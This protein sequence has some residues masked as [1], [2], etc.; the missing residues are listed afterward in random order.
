MIS[1]PM[2]AC[3]CTDSEFS[4]SYAASLEVRQ[5][6]VGKTVTYS[7]QPAGAKLGPRFP[8]FLSFRE[9]WDVCS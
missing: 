9:E 4:L 5:C 2:L 6:M 1:R 7:H 3:A 8:Q